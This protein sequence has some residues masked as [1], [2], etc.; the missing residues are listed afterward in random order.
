MGTQEKLLINEPGRYSS[1]GL[2][3]TSWGMLLSANAVTVF[4]PDSL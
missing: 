3:V 1:V 2:G 4:V